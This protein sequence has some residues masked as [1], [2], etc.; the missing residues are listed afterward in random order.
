MF[1]LVPLCVTQFS[2]S[3]G[4]IARFKT[5]SVYSKESLVSEVVR[6]VA[7]TSM[8]YSLARACVSAIDLELA[9]AATKS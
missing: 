3:D 8:D 4:A 1:I 2:A 7:S 6:N 5:T 9:K